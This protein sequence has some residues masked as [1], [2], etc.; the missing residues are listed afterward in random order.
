MQLSCL[1]YRDGSD[2]RADWNTIQVY[3]EDACSITV[4][5]LRPGS[6]YHFTVLARSHQSDEELFSEVLNATTQG[7]TA[8]AVHQHLSLSDFSFG[9]VG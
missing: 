7:T 8:A 4:Y 9:S 6:L 1:R 2:E 5:H 3:P